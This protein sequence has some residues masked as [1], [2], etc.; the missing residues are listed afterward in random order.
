M[1]SIKSYAVR[2]SH[3][4]GLL[5]AAADGRAAAPVLPPLALPLEQVEHL[6]RRVSKTLVTLL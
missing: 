1:W 3:V 2:Y 4:S 5:G 6:R